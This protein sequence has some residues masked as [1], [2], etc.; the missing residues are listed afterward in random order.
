MANLITLDE[1]KSYK[2]FTKTDNDTAINLIIGSVST[3]IKRVC[4]HSFIDYYNTDKIEYINIDPQTDIIILNEWPIVEIVDVSTKGTDGVY[5]TVDS[6]DYHVNTEESFIQLHSG[7]WPKGFGTVKVTYKAGYESTPDDVKIAALD[8][9][10]HY[11][12]EQ[13]IENKTLGQASID[14]IMTNK[15]NGR[16]PAH[17]IRV[18]DLYRNV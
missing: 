10:N 18:L 16:W 14:N 17:I 3:M 2:N 11:F 5:T 7:D 8:L 9:V 1:F 12:K 4:G 13:Y 15:P 6:D